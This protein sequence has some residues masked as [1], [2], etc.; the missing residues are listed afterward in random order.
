MQSYLIEVTLSIAD[1]HYMSL[2]HNYPISLLVLIGVNILVGYYSRE[3]NW[4][5]QEP[6]LYP[7]LFITYALF[8]L[9]NSKLNCSFYSA[10]FFLKR[11]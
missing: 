2:S 10:K 4:L 8:K 3:K 1:K 5:L 7:D 6:I 11:I 9:D